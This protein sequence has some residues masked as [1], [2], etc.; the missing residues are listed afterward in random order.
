MVIDDL[1][2]WV[3]GFFVFFALIMMGGISNVCRSLVNIGRQLEDI[4]RSLDW[5][6]RKNASQDMVEMLLEVHAEGYGVEKIVDP[7][8]QK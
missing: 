7:E 8:E 1:S 2:Q 5:L 4:G 3:G 6:N